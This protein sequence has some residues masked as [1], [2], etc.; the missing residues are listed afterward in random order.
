MIFTTFSDKRGL[1][2]HRQDATPEELAEFI[3]ATT[4][5]ARDRLPLVKLALF[6]E[7]R[8]DKG[9]LRHDANVTEVTGL[10]ADYDGGT[11]S[12]EEAAEIARLAG[13]HCIIYSSPSY[14]VE[15][16][17]WRVLAPF[18]KGYPP[19][20]RDRLF[21]RLAGLYAQHDI[22]F[23][24]ASWA[25]SQSYFIGGVN[26]SA[27]FVLIIPGE[28]IDQLEALDDVAARRPNGLGGNGAAGNDGGPVDEQA[29][30]EAIISGANYHRA[31]LSL[32]GHWASTGI[33]LIEARERL[34]TAF[35]CVFPA[36]RDQRWRDR[37]EEV[38]KLLGYV[39]GKEAGKQDERVSFAIGG[40]D[41]GAP[42]DEID[43][44]A[45]R[46]R[47]SLDHWVEREIPLRDRLLGDLLST[48]T[49]MLLVADTGLGKT[50]FALAVVFAVAQGAGFLHWLGTGEPHRVLYV[51]G[52]MSVR[53]MRDRIED[54]IRRAGSRPAGVFVLNT[55]DFA[56]M[57]P[58]SDRLGRLAVDKIISAL[59][60]VD[61]IVFDNVQALLAGDM[62]E[63]L[64]WKNVLGWVR[65][66]T[67]R[68]IAQ[69][70]IHHTGHDTT[71]SYG[72]KTREWQMDVVALLEA[73][74]RS[75]ADLA[76]ALKF[77]K[78]RERTPGNR[79]DFEPM[80]ITLTGDRWAS[81]A[82]GATGGKKRP[83]RDRALE[84]L[85]DAIARE[86]VVPPANTHI[87]SGTLCVTL[88]LWRRYC[89]AGLV[90]ES[91]GDADAAFRVA[92]Q[93]ACKGLLDTG[94]IGKWELWVWIIPSRTG[95]TS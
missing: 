44:A 61:L 24:P 77:T 85:R 94:Q 2:A 18:S 50:N 20:D 46:A 29:L 12:I 74:E 7:E 21:A 49:R 37:F 51:D 83:H 26:R 40:D 38:P 72:T 87:P 30:I 82:G 1:D 70:W 92:F 48:T 67:R 79:G 36:D 78:A 3:K 63:E 95:V 25:L 54:A 90:V 39:Y 60:G 43:E 23:D 45:L 8:S 4:R 28:P 31:S 34:V 89:L 64:P 80:I 5:E 9:C 88:G 11:A 75:G 47:L 27:P 84:L 32:L 52:E 14:T 76:F 10:E 68:K 86:G 16:P 22:V 55:E 13:L 35:E 33:G 91:E 15:K 41:E 71:R 19:E 53:L 65:D 57:P 93:R 59:G 58:L 69:I 81:E 62:K 56:E 17:R 6:G 42:N 73:D 66:L